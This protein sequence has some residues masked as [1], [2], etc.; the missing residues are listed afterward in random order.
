MAAI[1]EGVQ[2]GRPVMITPAKA[3]SPRQ[4]ADAIGMSKNFVLS[5]IHAGEIKALKF[6]NR[7]RIR[8]EEVAKYLLR[9]SFPSPDNPAKD[10]H[11]DSA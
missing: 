7:F 11:Q 2:E 3:W 4:L 9:R 6:G 8:A 5:E 10:D 1:C